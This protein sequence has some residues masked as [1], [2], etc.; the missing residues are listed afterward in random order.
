MNNFDNQIKTKLD[1]LIDILKECG[2]NKESVDLSIRNL[3]ILKES[4]INPGGLVDGERKSYGYKE[5]SK[6]IEENIIGSAKFEYF[7]CDMYVENVVGD[8]EDA[9]SMSIGE[10][11]EI[12]HEPIR[13]F[14]GSCFYR[15][16]VE[17]GLYDVMPD[18][19]KDK[20]V[21]SKKT[22][23]A[24]MSSNINLLPESLRPKFNLIKE[25]FSSSKNPF[26]LFLYDKSLSTVALSWKYVLH[27]T[28][29]ILKDYRIEDI[30]DP[31][32]L[33]EDEKEIFVGGNHLFPDSFSYYQIFKRILE[34]PIKSNLIDF[35]SFNPGKIE[36]RLNLTKRILD[37]KNIAQKYGEEGFDPKIIGKEKKH[38][39]KK[40]KDLKSQFNKNNAI[41]SI[42]FSII[43]NCL[44]LSE[45]GK[46]IDLLSEK[47]SSDRRTDLFSYHIFFG[48]I[49]L[50]IDALSSSEVKSELYALMKDYLI[51]LVDSI[52]NFYSQ[53]VEAASPII[54]ESDIEAYSKSIIDEFI[55]AKSS[56]IK[57]R[58][59]LGFKEYSNFASEV[60]SIYDNLDSEYVLREGFAEYPDISGEEYKEEISLKKDLML[61]TDLTDDQSKNYQDKIKFLQSLVRSKNVFKDRMIQ[62]TKDDEGKFYD[63]SLYVYAFIRI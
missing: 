22:L 51:Y 5:I 54:S 34:G 63:P 50:S 42:L 20:C 18:I 49:T 11:E 7:D 23:E 24:R 17:N 37:A 9:E 8:I 53:D 32:K 40:L 47:D 58:I 29:H 16:A 13:N 56:L 55:K 48:N 59:D 2:L 60:E 62:L 61:G 57:N 21:I 36:S 44:I 15:E 1:N 3:A 25:S 52:N 12:Y 38:L 41:N 6:A 39:M 43:K 27:D 19:I 31:N 30:I 46:K 45:S 35:V 4:S 28:I 10:L 33:T 14:I 26:F